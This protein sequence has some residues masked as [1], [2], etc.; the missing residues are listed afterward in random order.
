ARLAQQARVK[1][2]KL[3]VGE[4]ARVEV[5]LRDD[6]KLKG[7]I[8]AAGADTFTVTDARTGA[9]TV[10]AYND[11]LGV[12]KVGNGLST[13]TKVIIGGAAA[14]GV[15]IGWQIVKPALCDGGAQTRGIC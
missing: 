6:T 10:V 4:R 14:A 15:I 7:Y 11:V 3:G 12:K 13:M 1:I 8:S 2:L 5:K 9:S